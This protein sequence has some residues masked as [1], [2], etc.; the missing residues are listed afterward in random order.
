M[1]DTLIHTGLLRVVQRLVL[2]VE[3]ARIETLKHYE[4]VH[5]VWD[6]LLCRSIFK[7]CGRLC[8]H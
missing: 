5:L 3:D 7:S 4:V 8:I 6:S 1:R 2:E